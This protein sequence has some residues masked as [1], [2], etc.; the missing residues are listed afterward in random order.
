MGD[1]LTKAK[2]AFHEIEV[3]GVDFAGNPQSA[4]TFVRFFSQQVTTSGLPESNFTCTGNFESLFGPGVGLNLRHKIELT[5][6]PA[7]A[8]EQTGNSWN[9]L[10]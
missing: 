10:G 6:Y 7:G 3:G 9:R 8:P 5:V 4:L 1:L 2:Q